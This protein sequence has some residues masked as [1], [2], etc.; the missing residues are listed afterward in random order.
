MSGLRPATRHKLAAVVAAGV[1][2]TG[3]APLTAAAQPPG[4]EPLVA[5]IGL[6]RTQ[7][8]NTPA[9]LRLDIDQ[10]SPRVIRSDTPQVTVMGKVTN[11]GDR[12]IEQVEGRLQRGDGLADEGKL[13]A[14]MTQPP[15]A[16]AA[17]PSPFTQITKSLDTGASATFTATYTLDQLKLDQPGVYPMLV[18]VNGRPEY[19]GAER[20]PAAHGLVPGACP[21]R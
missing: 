7:P 11:V 5:P 10:L 9:R 21:A 3:S 12:R 14:A 16:A 1:L 4:P 2:L 18:N 8:A 20:L 15:A 19:G 6:A 13:R 17:A